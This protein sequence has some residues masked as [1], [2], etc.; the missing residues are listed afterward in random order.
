MDARDQ[1][2]L[3]SAMT[4]RTAHALPSTLTPEEHDLLLLYGNQHDATWLVKGD[5]PPPPPPPATPA[6]AP[7]ERP[8]TR[9]AVE[10]A[11]AKVAGILKEAFA[12]RDT[13]IAALMERAQSGDTAR[14]ALEQRNAELEQRVLSLE[15]D[16][17]ALTAVRDEEIPDADRSYHGA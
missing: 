13:Q 2:L 10:K 4:K 8:V 17:A 9:K 5:D 1:L 12:A 16:R 14:N 7:A 6:P 11:F 15:A 3:K